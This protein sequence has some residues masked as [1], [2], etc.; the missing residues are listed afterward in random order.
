MRIRP[1]WIFFAA[2]VVTALVYSPGFSGSWLFDDYPNIVDNQ[3]VQPQDASISSL[4]R[5]AL[6]SPSSEF[7][8]PLASLTFAANYLGSGL[9]PYGWK[10][11][12]V[13][14][15]LINGLLV[16]LLAR[17]LLARLLW[18][19]PDE[20]EAA[21]ARRAGICAA[22]VAAGWM[23]L[24][25][26][27]TAVLYIVQRMESMANAFVLLGLIGYVAG[28]ERMLAGRS[29]LWLCVL[30]VT[31]P[32]GLGLTAKETAVL[33][34]LYALLIEWVVFGFASQSTRH[35]GGGEAGIRNLAGPA[36][37]PSKIADSALARS[38]GMTEVEE[39]A[40]SSGR[41]GRGKRRAARNRAAAPSASRRSGD[42]ASEAGE[43]SNSVQRSAGASEEAAAARGRR[44]DWRL[45][46]LFAIVLL[47]PIVIGLGWIVLPHVLDPATWTS[48]DFTLATRL[49]SEAR[50]VIDYIGW[51]IVPLP[52][53]LSFYHD[54]F[55]ISTSVFK[56]WTTLPSILGIAA[57]IA[58]VP[59]LR[60]RQPLV[61]LGIA[62]FLACHTLTGT[63]LP[64]EL[65]YEHRNYFASFGIMLAIV[66]LLAASPRVWP[67]VLARRALLGALFAWWIALTL[68]TAWAWGDQL[69]L[70]QE[71]AARAPDS[72]RAQYELG[73]TYIIYSHY[74]PD[75]PYTPLVYAPLER[76]AAL[77][78]SSILPQQAL[79]FFNARMHRPIKDKWWDS[80]IAKLAA[81]DPGVQDESSLGA[82]T[83]CA[84]DGGCKL[85]ENRMVHAFLAA[86]SHPHPS[87]R[88][89]ATYG[90]YAWNI[91]GDQELGLRMSEE[92]STA[93]PDEPAYHIT[94]ARMAIIKGDLTLA[95]AHLKALES[96]NIGGR[97]DDRIASL[98]ALLGAP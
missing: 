17:M 14:I 88:L 65:V 82:L 97:L 3:G 94:V 8:R 9:D 60:R 12:N 52:H 79:I 31:V 73:R 33:L 35:S 39:A 64:L 96:L 45:F 37:V 25:I 23:L 58:A 44:H 18:R 6:S 1:W 87:A 71:L 32:V 66:P 68:F 38:S 15:H 10:V 72:P 92:A 86:L 81:H 13:A 28:R 24:P 75:S 62:L 70:A 34:P 91:L 29:G 40:R 57:L 48:R 63:I 7:K 89:L 55:V 43:A 21:Y 5:A 36:T 61:A 49:L 42:G 11:T 74:D 16:F 54:N 85:S 84:R 47:L 26:N 46:A 19:L 50:I 77:P 95:R 22:L 56:P 4:A 98:R 83:K 41:P 78:K 30:S 2:V 76:A 69:R 59:L 90:D 80:L 51:T 93:K 20:E 27:L 53:A 67:L